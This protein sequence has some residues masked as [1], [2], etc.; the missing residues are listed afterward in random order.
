VADGGD[1]TEPDDYF[2]DEGDPRVQPLPAT[3]SEEVAVEEERRT[4]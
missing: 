2:A 1:G 4:A 3:P